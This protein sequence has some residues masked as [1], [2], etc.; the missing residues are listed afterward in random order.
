MAELSYNAED[1]IIS[2]DLDHDLNFDDTELVPL[3]SSD[4]PDAVLMELMNNTGVNSDQN[5]ENVSAKKSEAD[6]SAQIQSTRFPMLSKDQIDDI[7]SNAIKPKTKK[8]T[9]WGIK[10]FRGKI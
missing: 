2:F 6:D 7:A 1:N 5:K 9:M 10:V 3:E 8:Q 4:V